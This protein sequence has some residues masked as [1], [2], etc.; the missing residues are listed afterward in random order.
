MEKRYYG[1]LILLIVIFGIVILFY[2][3]IGVE[4]SSENDVDKDDYASGSDGI[5]VGGK[6]GNGVGSAGSEDEERIYCDEQGRLAELCIEIYQPVCGWNDPEKI[7]CI[8]Y[9]CASTYS[10]SC[11]AC[12]NEEVLYYTNGECPA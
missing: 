10:N 12:M 6:V 5:G 11:F 9:P 3:Y 8:K 4:I 1:L 7:N 2:N